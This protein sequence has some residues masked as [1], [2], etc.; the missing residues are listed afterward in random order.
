MNEPNMSNINWFERW[1]TNQ[2]KN[3]FIVRVTNKCSDRCQHCCFRSGPEC[4]GSISVDDCLKLN[5][6]LPQNIRMNV[7]GGEVT[8]LDNYADIL[9]SL[10]GGRTNGAIITNGQWVNNEIAAT[11]FF[12]VINDLDN[13]CGDL[14]V[15]ISNDK[16]H[17]QYSRRALRLFRENCPSVK[18]IPGVDINPDQLLPL[19]R[20]WDNKLSSAIS[21]SQ[22][23]CC[24]ETGQLM[25]IETGKICLCPMGY[26]E[27]K[28]FW[29]IDYAKAQEYVWIWRSNQLDNGM[30]CDKCMCLLAGQSQKDI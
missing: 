22:C 26:F 6:W 2:W 28:Y 4:V 15:A 18:L 10:L 19:G 7:M 3:E 30:D 24:R 23:G 17:Q 1:T 12:R 11:N 29:E 14:C 5:I 16:W 20:A 21:T 25:V 8:V 9:F 13:V 27:W